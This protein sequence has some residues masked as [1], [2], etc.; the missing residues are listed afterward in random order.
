[1]NRP[2]ITTIQKIA[3]VISPIFFSRRSVSRLKASNSLPPVSMSEGILRQSMSSRTSLV[4]PCIRISIPKKLLRISFA[5]SACGVG[6][7]ANLTTPAGVSTA[8][9]HRSNVPL[10]LAV[11]AKTR[12]KRCGF[13]A[14][15]TVRRQSSLVT[16][17]TLPVRRSASIVMRQDRKYPIK[18]TTNPI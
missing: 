5:S 3:E 14:S 15:L 11:A 8:T 2:K 17:T 6:K 13:T 10:P 4:L 1:M 16:A 18:R 7:H 12:P 9:H